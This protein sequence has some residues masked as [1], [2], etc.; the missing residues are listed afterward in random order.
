MVVV[1]GFC[2]C[3]CLFVL[4]VLLCLIAVTVHCA[5]SK[6]VVQL[7]TCNLVA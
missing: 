2:C 3:C 6:T 1:V 7:F 5:V 4:L